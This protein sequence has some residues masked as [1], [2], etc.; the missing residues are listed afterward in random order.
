MLLAAQWAVEKGVVEMAQVAQV[1]ANK[2]A[3]EKAAASVNSY[4]EEQQ[5]YIEVTVVSVKGGYAVA[6]V[7]CY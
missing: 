3:A 1:F 7:S 5:M 2:E 6:V 4:L